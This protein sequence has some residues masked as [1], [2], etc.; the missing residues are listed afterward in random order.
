[1]DPLKRTRALLERHFELSA[2]GS[3]VRTELAAGTTTFLAMA[4]IVFV[5]PAVLSGRMFGIDTG[6][7]FGAVMTATC[8][9]AALASGLMGLYARAPIAQAPGMGENFFFALTLV[10][11]AAAAG[12]PSPWR[13][14]LG[15]VFVAGLLFLA[16]TLTGVRRVIVDAISPSLRAGIA[17][18]IGLFIAFIGLQNAGVIVKDPATAVRLDPDWL[19]PDL[20]VFWSGLLATI[21]LHARRVRGSLLAGIA[22]ATAVA[23]ALRFGLPEG[24]LADGARLA[25]LDAPTVPLSL[26]P[27]LSPTLLA[28][29]LRT[30]LSLALLPLVLVFLLMDLFDTV[31]T[32]VGVT[33]GAGVERRAL[34]PAPERAYLSDAVGTVAGAAMGTSTVTSFIESATGIGQGGRTGLTSVTTA[35]LFLLALFASP[36]VALVGSYPPITAPA[37]VVVGL[38]MLRSVSR[39]DWTEASE[40]L[41]AALIAIGIPLSFSISDGLALGFVAYP[42]AKALAGRARELRWPIWGT[43]AVMLLY[44]VLLR[45]GTAAP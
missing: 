22:V 4:Y 13:A 35:A 9:A 2:R 8:L 43:G 3:D 41:P 19:G 30:A 1:M 27:P 38:L 29:D 40:A 16:V 28:L 10:P 14:A 25:T 24:S 11:A 12:A 6:L 45:G 32:L 44:V 26:P 31:G 39:I 42:L 21:A 23:L 36:L 20:A 7:D 5:Q 33:E 34:L 17:A 15:V 18:G 37:L